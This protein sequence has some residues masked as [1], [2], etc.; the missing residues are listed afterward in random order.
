ML[1]FAPVPDTVSLDDVARDGLAADAG[2][3]LTLWT[4]LE[5]VPELDGAPVLVVDAHAMDHPPH[6]A[7]NSRVHVASVPARAIRNIDP[8]SP[9]RR[10]VAA[11]GYVTCPLD[12]DV[13]L[14][15][16]HRKG[17][18][19]LP[20]GKQEPGE[21]LEACALRE[22]R[23][24]VGIDRLRTLRPLGTTKHAFQADDTYKVKTTHW[25]Q[26]RTIARTFTPAREEDIRRVAWARWDVAYRHIGY[27]NL[28]EHMQQVES[29]V[30]RTLQEDERG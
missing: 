29:T 30:R 17:V 19:D 28:T 3:K 4:A 25:Y 14:L 26:M 12:D 27:T 5:A 15:V 10:V 20:K 11:G 7:T 23:E 1:L 24:E 9:P 13:A 16:I 21:T 2:E 22:V 8:Y 6:R 18:W